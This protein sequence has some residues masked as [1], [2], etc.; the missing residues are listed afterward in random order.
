M[1]VS[2]VGVP[3]LKPQAA[4]TP[5]VTRRSV[6]FT[7]VPRILSA[8]GVLFVASSLALPVLAYAEIGHKASSAFAEPAPTGEAD[9]MLFWNWVNFALLAGGLTYLSKRYAVPY[10]VKRSR[11]I[12]E[13]LT[14]AEEFGA[15]AGVKVAAIDRRIAGL[16]C[17][18]EAL[19]RG[20]QREREVETQRI[21]RETDAALLRIQ[22][23]AA[24]RVAT[25]GRTARL[26][27][28][29]YCSELALS[30]AEQKIATRIS[31]QMQGRLLQTFVAELS[32]RPPGA[33]VSSEA[34]RHLTG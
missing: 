5:A 30:V 2:G 9:G 24:E 6:R 15:E 14:D 12:R 31:P 28:R 16:G 33:D 17:E 19:R 34:L 27:L 25:A 18:V 1:C 3:R 8:A 32:R 22:A 26:E 10:F 7:R 20:A 4:T 29:R 23:Q 11:A 13:N 21:S